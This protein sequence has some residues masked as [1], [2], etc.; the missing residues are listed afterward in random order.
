M[1]VK[2][3]LVRAGFSTAVCL[4][5]VASTAGQQ[6]QQSIRSQRAASRLQE[7]AARSQSANSIRGAQR[8]PMTRGQQL[9]MQRQQQ[10]LTQGAERSQQAGGLARF[11]MNSMKTQTWRANQLTPRVARGSESPAYYQMRPTGHYPR[12]MDNAS[13]FD[14]GP[15]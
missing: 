8:I 14:R 15:E 6:T 10:S 13:Y 7:Q 1:R 12:F 3:A 9:G 4:I 2:V 11:G 5:L